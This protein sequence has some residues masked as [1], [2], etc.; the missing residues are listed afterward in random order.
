[1]MPGLKA[2]SKSRVDDHA[3]IFKRL[4]DSDQIAS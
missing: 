3:I 2:K 1:M 4:D